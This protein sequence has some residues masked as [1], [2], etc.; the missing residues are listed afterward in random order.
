MISPEIVGGVC[1]HCN[2][3][4]K[5]ACLGQWDSDSCPNGYQLAQSHYSEALRRAGD[6]YH[7]TV[8]PYS[9]V[10]LF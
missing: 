1:Q 3:Q 10:G 8:F 6:I 4:E 2:Y 9:Y 5:A 7:M